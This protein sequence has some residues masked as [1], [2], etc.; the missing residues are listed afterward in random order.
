MPAWRPLAGLS[1]SLSALLGV[2]RHGRPALPPL[3]RNQHDAAIEPDWQ[4]HTARSYG[5]RLI[6]PDSGHSPFLT[7]PA[8]LANVLSSL[9]EL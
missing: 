5:A 2:T 7:Q 8:E 1:R 6:E 9:P 4:I 3:E